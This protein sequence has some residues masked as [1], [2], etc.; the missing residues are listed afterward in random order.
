[1]SKK[2]WIALIVLIVVAAL[3]VGVFVLTKKPADK[4]TDEPKTTN[5]AETKTTAAGD[6]TGGTGGTAGTEATQP[7]AKYNFTL[8]IVHKDGQKKTIPV[9]TNEEILG[10]YLA[11][12]GIIEGAEGPYGMYIAK[13][14]G[15]KAVYEEDAAYWAFYIDG[16][17]ALT[18]VDQTQIE[19]GKVYQLKYEAAY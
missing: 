16:E 9:A 10:E 3:L 8:E 17:Y 2:S 1:M 15:E 13:V 7:A 11:A 6:A 14:E 19:S 18:G 5:G 4:K 12:E